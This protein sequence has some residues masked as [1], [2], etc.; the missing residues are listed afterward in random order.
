MT[1]TRRPFKSHAD[2][3]AWES[4]ERRKNDSAS[5]SVAQRN[6]WQADAL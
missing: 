2:F 4:R 5:S 3:N 1:Q 6:C